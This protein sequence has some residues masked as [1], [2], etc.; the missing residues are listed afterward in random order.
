MFGKVSRPKEKNIGDDSVEIVL[1]NSIIPVLF[2]YGKKKGLE[3]FQNKALD[4]LGQ[5]A[6]EK[7]SVIEKWQGLGVK[8]NNAFQSQALLHLKNCYCDRHR[9]L[10]CSIGSKILSNAATVAS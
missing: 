8:V 1:I 6:P 4:L 5:L 2:I 3:Q 9:C 7:N 10:E